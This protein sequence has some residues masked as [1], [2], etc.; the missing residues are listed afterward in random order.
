MNRL[1]SRAWFFAAVGTICY[2]AGFNDE[3]LHVVGSWWLDL[4]RLVQTVVVVVLLAL[5][6]YLVIDRVRE[7]QSFYEAAVRAAGPSAETSSTVAG[8]E[9]REGS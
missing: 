8:T 6:G 5:V 3:L 4:S 9:R 7:R 2:L 1:A